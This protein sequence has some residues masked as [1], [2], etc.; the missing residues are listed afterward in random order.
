M[1]RLSDLKVGEWAVVKKVDGDSAIRRRLETM[2]FLPGVKVAVKRCAP[3]GDPRAYELL[4]YCISLRQE[5]AALVL[6]EHLPVYSLLEAPAG[7]LQVVEISGGKGIRIRLAEIG[8]VAGKVITR[9]TDGK[10]GPVVVEVEGK[11]VQ[12]GR[13]MA[14]RV[15]VMVEA[16]ES[17]KTD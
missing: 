12:I 16:S 3:M 5:E 15:I 1:I 9:Q 14:C 17:K 6:V 11:R 2:G 10:S 7:R 8:I 4:G 13:G